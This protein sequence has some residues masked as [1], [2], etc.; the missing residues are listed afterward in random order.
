MG[1][2]NLLVV[3]DIPGCELIQKTCKVSRKANVEIGD[4]TIDAPEP[5]IINNNITVEPADVVIPDELCV[6]ILPQCCFDGEITCDGCKLTLEGTLTNNG[7]EVSFG[8]VVWCN[9]DGVEIATGELCVDLNEIDDL[10]HIDGVYTAKINSC[11]CG[12]YSVTHEYERADAGDT[13]HDEN[14]PVDLVD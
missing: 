5:P 9:P 13:V 4:I 10:L 7:N 12:E 6:K 1:E 14:N 8:D 3:W 2:G 11:E